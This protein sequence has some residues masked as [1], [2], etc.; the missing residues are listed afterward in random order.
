MMSPLA[1]DL[2]QASAN[3]L[4]LRDGSVA[5]VRRATP[6][7]SVAMRQFFHD[8]SP[9]SRRRRFFSAGEVPDKL[10][11]SLCDNTDPSKMMTLIAA[12]QL[13]D[14]MHLIA[15]CMYAAIN[16]T[17]A[18]AAFAVDDRFHGKGLATAMLERLAALA[19]AQGFRWFQATTLPENQAMLEVF[20]DSGFEMRSKSDAGTVDVRLTVTPTEA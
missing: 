3:R 1:P 17:T 8:L 12:R 15:V 11:D 7:D 5:A 13:P 18:E 14:G 9:E 20:R 2:Q 16:Q 6:D 19:T 4:V 10:I